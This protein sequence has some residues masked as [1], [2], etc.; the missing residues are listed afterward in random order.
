MSTTAVSPDL[1]ALDA[2]LNQSIL[3]GN[4]ME[5][6]EKFYADDIVMQENSEAPRIGKEI[7]RK[8]ELD[9]LSSV[10]E[11]HG[12][13]LLGSAVNGDRSYSEW[14]IDA[15]YKNGQ[16]HKLA[17]VAVRQWKNGQVVHERF[18]YSK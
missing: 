3:S 15:T 9:F 14:E 4:I 8:A 10:Q 17:Q 6:F 7:N 18:Y 13:N 5:A 12:A 11:F 1:K 2:E 16:R